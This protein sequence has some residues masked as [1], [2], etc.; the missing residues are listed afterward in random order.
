[1]PVNANK[2]GG[3]LLAVIEQIAR[4]Q[5]I[6]VRN[7]ARVMDTEKSAVQ[8]AV[9]T[10]AEA[11][12]IHAPAGPSGGWE[13]TV[14]ILNLALMS[15]GSNSLRQRI[16]PLLN[17]L[18]DET[19]ETA[20]LAIPDTD[21]LV[22]TEVAESQQSLRLVVP[23]GVALPFRDSAAGR[24]ILAHLPA[25]ERE[26]LLGGAPTGEFADMLQQIVAAGHATICDSDANTAVSIASPVFD[27]Q[28]RPVGA[29]VI[30]AVGA[31]TSPENQARF[32]GLLYRAA[33]DLSSAGQSEISLPDL[34]KAIGGFG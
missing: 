28:G 30:S 27:M 7:L 9:T 15:H 2:S 12:W 31:R 17:S 29:L 32:S 19:G 20:Y 10:L 33:R 4:S 6:G 8:R 23:V 11:G 13:L 18:R 21:G 1:L 5:P 34:R 25:G 24:A 26:V 14:R 3:R 22:V 16:R